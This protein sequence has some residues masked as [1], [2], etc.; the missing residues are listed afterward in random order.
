[1]GNTSRVEAGVN[2][3]EQNQI[4]LKYVAYD[5]TNAEVDFVIN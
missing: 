4:V 3:S 2:Q 1:M 5:K